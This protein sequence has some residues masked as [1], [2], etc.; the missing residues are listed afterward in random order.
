VALSTQEV[1]GTITG[2]SEAAQQAGVAVT[3]VLGGAGDVSR[4]ATRLSEELDG[5]VATLRAA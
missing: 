5:F 2:V 3:H 4:Q 1:T